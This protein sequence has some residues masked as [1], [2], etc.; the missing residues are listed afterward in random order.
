[1]ER[2]WD[3]EKYL[4]VLPFYIS[5]E[6]ND[7]KTLALFPFYGHLENWLGFESYDFIMF[8]FYSSSKDN[9]EKSYNFCW[10]FFNY[11]FSQGKR[12]YRIWPFYGRKFLAGE[13]EREFILWPFYNRHKFFKDDGTVDRERL[14]IFPFYGH[15]SSDS[16][17]TK[18]FMFPLYMAQKKLKDDYF[19]YDALWP[20]LSYAR[21]GKRKVTQVF[22]LFRIEEK[23]DSFRN[24]YLWPLFWKG[25]IR[26]SGYRRRFFSFV[27]LYIY[28]RTQWEKNGTDEK[29]H[30][31]WP[32]FSYR[33]DG[34]SLLVRS[35]EIIPF[36][37]KGKFGESFYKNIGALFSLWEYHKNSEENSVGFSFLK[38]LF[39][40]E[41][42]EGLKTFK[43]FYF[44]VYKSGTP[45]KEA[46][47]E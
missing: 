47:G 31:V 10:P 3:R 9:E 29:L 8:P 42:K 44:P 6:K 33:N 21:G 4:Y 36:N 1:M 2:E 45:E 5:S 38:G 11:S 19:R 34:N 40:Y 20:F 27:P 23:G 30:K 26:V 24:F 17:Q 32:L 43:F 41:R 15:F 7:K 28:N 22:P 14:L 16:A 25:D 39:G 18:L 37:E 12:Y 13:Y 46:A 35:L